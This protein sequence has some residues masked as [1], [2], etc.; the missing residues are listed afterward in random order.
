MKLEW[1]EKRGEGK[2]TR[3]IG[4]VPYGVVPYGAVPFLLQDKDTFFVN[5]VPSSL[6]EEY[7]G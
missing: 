4:V 6:S 2:E 7:P 5:Y 1:G 3:N